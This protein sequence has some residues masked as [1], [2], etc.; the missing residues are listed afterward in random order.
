MRR[1]SVGARY[2]EGTDQGAGTGRRWGTAAATIGIRTIL[3]GRSGLA[4]LCNDGDI[5]GGY[6]KLVKRAVSN[7]HL[8]D[9]DVASALLVGFDSTHALGAYN[10]ARNPVIL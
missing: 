1:V 8:P 7:L 10:T 3:V 9:C 5:G 6:L 2:Q 4:P